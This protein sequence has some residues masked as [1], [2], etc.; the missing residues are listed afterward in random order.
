MLTPKQF[1]AFT[2]RRKR[3]IRHM[4]IFIPRN[5]YAVRSGYYRDADIALLLRRH[6]RNAK[7]V[8]FVAEQCARQ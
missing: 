1:N 5:R 7:T 8:L 4:Y 2:S 6:Y 3:E